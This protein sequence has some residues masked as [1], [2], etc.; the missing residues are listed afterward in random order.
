[1][2]GPLAAVGPIET[3]DLEKH[4][5]SQP[6]LVI[7]EAIGSEPLCLVLFNGFIKQETS[8]RSHLRL[9]GKGGGRRNQKNSHCN[10]ISG[11]HAVTI[12][13]LV[14]RCAALVVKIC[15][16]PSNP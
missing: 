2:A 8:H 7:S 6:G 12:L 15:H 14:W 4:V 1:M 5:L 9:M 16:W 10:P 3:F 11:L 13:R